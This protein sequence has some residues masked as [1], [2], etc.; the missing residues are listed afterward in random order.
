MG[1]H[2]ELSGSSSQLR[3]SSPSVFSGAVG[4]CA[5]WFNDGMSV[6]QGDAVVLLEVW[7]CSSTACLC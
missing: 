3:V 1:A 5:C 6:V 7:V 4:I 2:R